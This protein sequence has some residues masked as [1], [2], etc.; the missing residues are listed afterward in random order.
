VWGTPPAATLS[1]SALR[2]IPTG[3]GN[4]P[5]VVPVYRTSHGSSPRVWGTQCWC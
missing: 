4:T 1:R 5:L 3:V 2:I